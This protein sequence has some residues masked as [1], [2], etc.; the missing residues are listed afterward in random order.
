MV[1]AMGELTSDVADLDV[2]LCEVLTERAD[3]VPIPCREHHDTTR[4]V[5]GGGGDRAVMTNGAPGPDPRTEGNPD[6]RETA[7]LSE[8]AESLSIARGLI[9]AGIP[10]FI[11]KPATNLDGSWNPGG[12]HRDRKSVV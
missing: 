12:G 4:A 6:H 10:V 8:H 9:E 2:Q 1:I 11:A 7:T 3:Q 5:I